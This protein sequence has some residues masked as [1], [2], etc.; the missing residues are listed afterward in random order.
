MLESVRSYLPEKCDT[1]RKPKKA[2]R[3]LS[4]IPHMKVLRKMK[5]KESFGS[6]CTYLIREICWIVINTFF[7]TI[8]WC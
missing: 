2:G 5:E 7:G 4:C 6:E 3:H 8:L 1:K